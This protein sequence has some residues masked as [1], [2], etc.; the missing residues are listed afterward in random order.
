MEEGKYGVK[1]VGASLLLKGRRD[2]VILK[3]EI[4]R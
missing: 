1:G 2:A 4:R 3:V